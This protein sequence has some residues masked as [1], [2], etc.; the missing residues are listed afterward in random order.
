M[1]QLALWIHSVVYVRRDGQSLERSFRRRNGVKR[2]TSR[3]EQ[4]KK[5]L[6]GNVI[7]AN[8]DVC[9][10]DVIAKRSTPLSTPLIIQFRN[11][12]LKYC[13]LTEMI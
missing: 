10:C 1:G 13:A 2:R 6:V 5:V 12:N 3:V 11:P 9:K 4:K 7:T 8:K